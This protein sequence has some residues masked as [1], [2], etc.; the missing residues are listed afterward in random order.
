M[1]SKMTVFSLQ[2]Q[3]IYLRVEASIISLKFRFVLK[4]HENP[5]VWLY[6]LYFSP[7]NGIS[8]VFDSE[9]GSINTGTV[10]VP[11]S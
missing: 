9:L 4:T 10:L 7:E 3:D 6:G 11:K 1:L 5:H 8:A 2:V